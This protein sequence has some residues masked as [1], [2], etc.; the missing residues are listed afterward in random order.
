MVESLAGGGTNAMDETDLLQLVMDGM[1][2]EEDKAQIWFNTP[3]PLLYGA[4][5]NEFQL[6][7]G[8]QKL[9]QFIETQLSENTPNKET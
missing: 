2:W 6:M 1:S 4:T 3:N 7:R 8:K 5:P 9:A